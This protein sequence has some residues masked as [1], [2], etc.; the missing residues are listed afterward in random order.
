MLKRL[1]LGWRPPQLYRASDIIITLEKQTFISG[2][3][4]SSGGS[5]LYLFTASCANFKTFIAPYDVDLSIMKMCQGVGPSIWALSLANVF[6]EQVK[7]HILFKVQSSTVFMY[8][9]L[10][11]AAVPRLGTLPLTETLWTLL[12]IVTWFK[13]YYWYKHVV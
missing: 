12:I 4:A 8:P 3:A 1:G 2:L 7:S 10:K 5:S 9:M 11:L 6:G 13:Y